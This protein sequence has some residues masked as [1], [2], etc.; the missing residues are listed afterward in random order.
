MRGGG[1]LRPARAC[2]WTAAWRPLGVTMTW[3]VSGTCS[4]EARWRSSRVIA[5]SSRVGVGSP[6]GWLWARTKLWAAMSSAVRRTVE[7]P[8]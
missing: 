2:S 6:L 7:R 3:A 1:A 5:S 8:M 4:S